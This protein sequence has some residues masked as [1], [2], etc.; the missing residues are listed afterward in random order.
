M[1]CGSSELPALASGTLCALQG[2]CCG[3][4]TPPG[5][6]AR[7][8]G[9]VLAVLSVVTLPSPAAAVPE[10]LCGASVPPGFTL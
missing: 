10:L 1:C 5:S 9:P 8:V 3:R 6:E 7:A 4:V 2:S